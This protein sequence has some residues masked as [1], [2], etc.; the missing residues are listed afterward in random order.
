MT[1]M[2]DDHRKEVAKFVARIKELERLHL[3][4]QEKLK[5]EKQGSKEAVAAMQ[6]DIDILK[7]QLASLRRREAQMAEALKQHDVQFAE[8]RR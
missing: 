7:E 2:R 1:A 3:A 5:Q 6:R 4:L 8:K